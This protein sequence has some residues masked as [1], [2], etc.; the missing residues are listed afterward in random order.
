MCPHQM[1]GLLP[2]NQMTLATYQSLHN[3]MLH[4][5]P[6]CQWRYRMRWWTKN[7]WHNTQVRVMAVDH[8]VGRSRNGFSKGGHGNQWHNNMMHNTLQPLF[9]PRLHQSLLLLP[10]LLMRRGRLHTRL[11]QNLQ[12][13][14]HV[15][16]SQGWSM[17]HLKAKMSSHVR[18]KITN[19][20]LFTDCNSELAG[21]A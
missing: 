20:Q 15:P 2:R 10:N 19:I 7:Q 6:Q 14:P 4:Q 5:I 12:G 16:R 11:H 8:E 21:D 13:D 17:T 18:N 9:H 1:T 3:M